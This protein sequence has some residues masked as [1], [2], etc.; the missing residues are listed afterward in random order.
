MAKT[1]ST[2]RIGCNSPASTQL[3]VIRGNS[4]S[5]K[6]TIAAAIRERYGRGLATVGLSHRLPRWPVD[7]LRFYV[8]DM[9]MTWDCIVLAPVSNE[10]ALAIWLG[11]VRISWL[12][13]VRPAPIRM[14]ERAATRSSPMAGRPAHVRTCRIR[15]PA[16]HELCGRCGRMA[17]PAR[18]EPDGTAICYASSC[19]QPEPG[20][21]TVCGKYKPCSRACTSSAR[22][23]T[24][25]KMMNKAPCSRCGA[26]R[27]VS[28]RTADGEPLCQMCGAPREACSTCGRIRR[29][30]ARPGGKPL[31]RTCY[32]NDP[33]SLRACSNCGTTAQT[34][35]H[36][37]C[38]ACAAPG[39]VRAVLSVPGQP[40]RADLEPVAGALTPLLATSLPPWRSGRDQSHRPR[41][42]PAIESRRPATCRADGGRAAADA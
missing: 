25:V 13:V 29:V 22:C 4:A 1:G 19:R 17:A 30:T 23:A 26:H 5:G 33:S 15:D 8:T 28:H 24:C 32:R 36:G 16:R 21:C 41:P 34:Y 38:H 10:A 2:S 14:T 20:T 42:D 12:V 11:A 39:Q 35:H 3:I 37:L 40:M 6:S 7:D 27:A 18:H 31:C 9:F